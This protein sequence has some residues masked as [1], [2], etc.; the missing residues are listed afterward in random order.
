MFFKSREL[1][2]WNDNSTSGAANVWGS[3]SPSAYE[4]TTSSI[5]EYRFDFSV[6]FQSFWV[7]VKQTNKA[8]LLLSLPCWRLGHWIPSVCL[9]A[10]LASSPVCHLQ[11]LLC[12]FQSWEEMISDS[13]FAHRSQ[14]WMLSRYLFRPSFQFVVCLGFQWLLWS[15]FTFGPHHAP[16]RDADPL[17]DADGQATGDYMTDTRSWL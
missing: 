16:A 6:E 2:C 10:T 9:K 11:P 13:T 4:G 15:I 5:T 7:M 14:L 1:I 3:K 8:S 12:S 17:T